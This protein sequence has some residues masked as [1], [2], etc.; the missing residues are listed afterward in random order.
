MSSSC[1]CGTGKSIDQCC[2]LYL[3]GQTYPNNAEALMRS[4][5]SA[6]ITGNIPYLKKTWHPDTCPELTSDD[7]HTNWLRLDVV[8]SKKG[9]KKSVV[10]F[11]AWFDEGDSERAL[12]EI[13]LFKLH[14]KRWVYVGPLDQWP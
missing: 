2:G 12:H 4:R 14:K 3:S 8:R 5:Y 9:L 11:K 1:P 13:S 10:E 6:Y 7:L